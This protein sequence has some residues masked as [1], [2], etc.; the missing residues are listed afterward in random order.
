[1]GN[2][3][4]KGRPPVDKPA[5]K[6]LAGVRVTEEQLKAYKQKAKGEG[7]TF[8]EWVREVL[9]NALKRNR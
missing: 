8:S 3:D 7:K 2:K 9:D 6:S 5:N 4:A 1:M